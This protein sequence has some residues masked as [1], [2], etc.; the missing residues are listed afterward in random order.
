ME[1]M[2]FTVRGATL[3]AR[4]RSLAWAR[5]CSAILGFLALA[6]SACSSGDSTTG[7]AAD[8]GDEPW[9]RIKPTWDSIYAGYF[10]PSGVASCTGGA[11]CHS[12]SDQSGATAS[13]FIC[14]DKDSCF[15][16]LTGISHLILAQDVLDPASTKLLGRL[17]QN[18]GT[19]KMPGDSTFVFQPQD[20]DVL[21]AWIAK[22]AKND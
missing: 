19:G 6:A 12:S 18:S 1:R 8:A 16:S 15:T 3:R 10:G 7:G 5:C 14:P 20:I 4:P 13:N 17:R 9:L 2:P 21:E 11:A 22:G